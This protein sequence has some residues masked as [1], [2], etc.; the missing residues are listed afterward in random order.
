M[1]DNGN[2][3]PVA[4]EVDSLN[5]ESSFITLSSFITGSGR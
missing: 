3:N 2:G 5:N 1:A 4:A